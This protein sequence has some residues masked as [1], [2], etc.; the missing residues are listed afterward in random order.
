MRQPGWFHATVG[1]C[2]AKHPWHS[3]RCTCRPLGW[4]AQ[5]ALL[6]PVHA[7]RLFVSQAPSRLDQTQTSKPASHECPTR[8]RVLVQHPAAAQPDLQPAG[9][10]DVRMGAAP[11]RQPRLLLLCVTAAPGAD[12][13]AR[14]EQP[15]CRLPARLPACL[16]CSACWP[17]S[18]CVQLVGCTHCP[19]VPE[20]RAASG[21]PAHQRML[22]VGSVRLCCSWR[23][24]C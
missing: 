5:L 22:T 8:C 20:A 15:R 4:P 9:G 24:G 21:C 23:G 18:L 12:G 13:A 2:A 7:C 17:A 3:H 10:D 16:P 14:G 19:V 11:T 6:T 1:G